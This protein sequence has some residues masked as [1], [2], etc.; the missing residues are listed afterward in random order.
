MGTPEPYVVPKEKELLP[1]TTN[2]LTAKQIFATEQIKAIVL[3]VKGEA[4]KHEPDTSTDKGRKAIASNARSVSSSKKALEVIATARKKEIKIETKEEVSIIQTGINY[5]MAEL[6]KLRDEKRKPYTDWEKKQEEAAAAEA[7]ASEIAEAH[8]AAIEIN[9]LMDRESKVKEGLA[10]IAEAEAKAA[11]EKAE[12][13]R[14]ARE[15]QIRKEAKAEAEKKATEKLAKAKADKLKDIQDKKDLAAK[16]EQ[17]KR[18]ASVR[19]NREQKEAVEKARR[20]AAEKAEQ[21]E[22]DRLAKE[23]AEKEQAE[24]KAANKKHRAKIKKESLRFIKGVNGIT[25]DQA[26]Q[27]FDNISFGD[28]PHITVNY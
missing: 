22:R 14:L 12:K 9:E 4:D 26:S 2:K 27:L 7:I 24:K 8:E 13:E 28:V 15:E 17:D 18:D 10:K 1:A 16:T 11:T 25:E 3:W 21:K 19:A 23:Q 5:A 20:E 6:D